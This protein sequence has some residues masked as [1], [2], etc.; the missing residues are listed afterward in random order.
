VRALAQR[1]AEAAK[2]IKSL[3]STSSAEVGQG[4]ELVGRT[5]QA[6]EKIVTQV[7]ELEAAVSNITARAMEQAT[8]LEDIQSVVHQ[9]DRN[10]Q[11]NA[12]MAEETMRASSVLQQEAKDLASM[13]SG[14][15]VG[16]SQ[17]PAPAVAAPSSKS[18]PV[19]VVS[20]KSA[21]RS[22][23]AVAEKADEWEEF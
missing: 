17:S 4:V 9:I 5:G 10:T 20:F 13:V 11:T 22:A 14:F 15:R 18:P 3:I 8:S 12:A 6:L 23:A 21:N 16:R 1:S 19:T 2:E 7:V